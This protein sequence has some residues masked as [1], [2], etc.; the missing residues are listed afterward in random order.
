MT[1]TMT[2][3]TTRTA[4]LRPV[5]RRVLRWVDAGAPEAE[6]ARRFRRS[7]QWV[8]RVRKLAELDRA[9]AH[10]SAQAAAPNRA[11]P[12]GGR[13]RP[14]ERR[15]LRWRAQGIDHA[16]LSSRF[17]RSPEFLARVERYARYKLASDAGL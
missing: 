16:E 6:I 2:G 10:P 7:T 17:R 12:T 13:L 8:A 3:P 5:E 1:H 4:R 11:I 14:L 15:L 9:T